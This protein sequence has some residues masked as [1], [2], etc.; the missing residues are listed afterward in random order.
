MRRFWSLASTLVVA[1]VLALAGCGGG[2]SGPSQSPLVIG[3]ATT[4]SGDAQS[5]P[6][7]SPLPNDLRV[8]VTRDGDPAPDVAVAWSTNG[9]GSL[10]PSS[11]TTDADGIS[12]STWTLGSTSGAQSATAGI[13]GATGSPVSFT[14]TATGGAGGPTIMVL[15][16]DASN[17]TNRFEPANLTVIV[18]R[19]VTWIWG[20]NAVGHNI[21]PDDG[22]TPMTSGVLA[23]APHSYQY[24]FGT[25][26]TFHYHCQSHGTVNGGGMSGTITVIASGD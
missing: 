6:V 2:D 18:G 24:T 11:G 7:G 1:A 26:G 23:S 25:L 3:K 20:E 19:T 15:S 13:T 4:K 21:I 22:S 10:S 5:G 12:S 16:P 9:G 14:A 17:P 8:V